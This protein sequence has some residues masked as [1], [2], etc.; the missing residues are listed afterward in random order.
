MST[1][2]LI[3][4]QLKDGRIMFRRKSS[5]GYPSNVVPRLLT[6]WNTYKKA[7]KLELVGEACFDNYYDIEYADS[8]EDFLKSWQFVCYQYLFKDNKWYIGEWHYNDGWHYDWSTGKRTDRYAD[9]EFYCYLPWIP[10]ENYTTKKRISYIEYTFDD[11]AYA[12]LSNKA[13][14]ERRK[15]T[16]KK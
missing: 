3:G 4:V 10:V 11:E 15:N 2:A 6:Y 5:D 9:E 7:S 16:D 1:T 8:E 13:Y 14:E 12:E